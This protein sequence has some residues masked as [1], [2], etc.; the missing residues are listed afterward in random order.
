MR[1]PRLTLVVLRAVVA[2]HAHQ[3]ARGFT[4]G[5]VVVRRDAGIDRLFERGLGGVVLAG[6]ALRETE[7]IERRG[8]ERAVVGR[9]RH[10]RSVVAFATASVNLP[11]P[12]SARVS[13]TAPRSSSIRARSAGF[14]GG[15]IWR[16]QRRGVPQSAIG[17]SA[18]AACTDF[19]MTLTSACAAR[20]RTRGA[21]AHAGRGTPCAGRAVRRIVRRV[22]APRT[23]RRAI[24]D[25]AVGVVIEDLGD[26]RRFDRRVASAGLGE[27]ARHLVAL[28]RIPCARELNAGPRH[29]WV[30]CEPRPEHARRDTAREHSNDRRVTGGA[31]FAIARRAAPRASETASPDRPRGRG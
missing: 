21:R 5:R 16:A 23:L 9:T 24:A 26:A 7:C 13:A 17:V 15:R 29:S 31:A 30:A 6:V 28:R 19:S 22:R 8:F 2:D 4:G 12:S 14:A 27:R 25:H 20:P 11:A 10:S 1:D 3:P 18:S